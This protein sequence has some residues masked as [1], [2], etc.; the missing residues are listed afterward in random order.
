V[1][2]R[3]GEVAAERAARIIAAGRTRVEE[4]DAGAAVLR[5][6]HDADDRDGEHREHLGAGPEA[7]VGRQVDQLEEADDGGERREQRAAE[8]H[9]Q[10]EAGDAEVGRHAGAGQRRRQR[11][12]RGRGRRRLG[13]TRRVCRAHPANIGF[14][15]AEPPVA[16]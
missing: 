10:A 2:R 13:R 6:A 11:G 8:L 16:R 12:R 15:H 9:E 5:R 3:D 4:G 1:R 14:R 7:R